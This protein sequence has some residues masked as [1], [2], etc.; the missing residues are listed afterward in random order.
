MSQSIKGAQIYD[1]VICPVCNGDG[2]V[3]GGQMMK[4]ARIYTVKKPCPKCKGKGRIGVE[5]IGEDDQL[6]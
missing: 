3:H 4:D 1:I 5:R 2:T 6:Q